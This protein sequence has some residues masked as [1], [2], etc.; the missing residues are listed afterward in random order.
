MEFGKKMNKS[1]HSEGKM[2]SIC[3]RTQIDK[4]SRPQ[5]KGLRDCH[6]TQNPPG[7]ALG[8]NLQNSSLPTHRAHRAITC[9]LTFAGASWRIFFLP[10]GFRPKGHPEDF[11]VRDELLKSLGMLESK[12]AEWAEERE[13]EQW[14]TVEKRI[15]NTI[16]ND[17]WERLN[18]VETDR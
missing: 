17:V 4:K 15:Q 1:L 3:N 13:P 10:D 8:A 18:T 14:T 5:R 6:M 11:T 16:D 9:V 2:S 7:L 12:M